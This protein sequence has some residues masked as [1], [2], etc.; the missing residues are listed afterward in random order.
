MRFLIQ[1]IRL[2]LQ[3][4]ELRP[5]AFRVIE[6]WVLILAIL[7]ILQGIFF[8]LPS[9]AQYD[10]FLSVASWRDDLCFSYTCRTSLSVL[11]RASLM[12]TNL[13]RLSLSQKFLFFFLTLGSLALLY[14][15]P[16]TGS[17][18]LSELKTHHFKTFQPLDFQLN[19]VPFF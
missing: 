2:C 10:L 15:A 5:L 3:I 9:M 19:N 1:S 4:R 8:F 12:T 14:V 18:Y 13:F 17:G 16:W 11:C 6:S 7:L